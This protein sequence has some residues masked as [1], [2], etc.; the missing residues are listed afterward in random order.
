MN[1]SLVGYTGF[2]GGNL[3]MS[4]SFDGLYN[5]KNISDAF[6]KRHDLVVYCGVRAEK[7]LANS[8]PEGDRKL[9]DTAI[10]NIKHMAPRRLVLISTSDV[11]KSPNGVDE[12]TTIDTDGLHP[13][14]LNR[15][16][17]ERWVT[18]NVERSLVVRLPGLYGKGLKKNFIYDMITLVPSM[19]KAEKYS[20]LSARCT[21]VKNGYREGTN[22]FFKLCATGSELA[23]LRAFFEHNDFNSLCFTDSRAVYQFYG[24]HNL[25]HDIGVALENKLRL[26]N[27]VAEP[28][29][30][31]ETYEYVHGV[32]FVNKLASEP[33]KYDLRSVSAELFGGKNGYTYSREQSLREIKE[34]VLSG[35]FVST[36]IQGG[37]R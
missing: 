5:S 17:L 13:Y 35:T 36:G 9:I 33:V 14:G 6:G 24:L 4:H 27:L 16:A 15:Y 18:E 34:G 21:L 11:Y 19:L 25:W 32:P 37:S 30:A 26:V 3:N 23:A 28:V 2:V 7:Y 20:E 22:G 29:S 10:E 1:I 31:A 12:N 8:D